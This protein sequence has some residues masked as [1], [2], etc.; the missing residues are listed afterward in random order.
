MGSERSGLGS[1]TW[2]LRE[3]G[4]GLLGTE[5]QLSRQQVTG[6]LGPPDVREALS[7]KAH[8]VWWWASA[9]QDPRPHLLDPTLL[10][11]VTPGPSHSGA[12]CAAL[13]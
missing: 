3:A 13:A 10:V 8:G 6:T 12:Q 4:T 5:G 1:A 9:P 2:Q 11:H 7:I